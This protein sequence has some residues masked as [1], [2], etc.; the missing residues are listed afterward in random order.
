MLAKHHCKYARLSMDAHLIC[1]FKA[2]FIETRHYI[3]TIHLS[4]QIY[5]MS[6]MQRSELVPHRKKKKLKM[7]Y[8]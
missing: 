6:Y 2:D 3:H 5:K 8:L 1:C 4:R 7:N